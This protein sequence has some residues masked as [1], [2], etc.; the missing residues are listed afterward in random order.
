MNF[1]LRT[2]KITQEP[3]NDKNDLDIV[4]SPKIERTLPQ[5]I[6]TATI[7]KHRYKKKDEILKPTHINFED[8][9]QRVGSRINNDQ[10][11]YSGLNETPKQYFPPL[12]SRINTIP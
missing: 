7:H 8:S 6:L 3:T 4:Q 5:F 1:N 11:A 9:Y 12:S 10:R 2:D